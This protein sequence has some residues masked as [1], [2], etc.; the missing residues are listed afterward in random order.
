MALRD[1]RSL[2]PLVTRVVP[3][4]GRMAP[5]IWRFE[6]VQRQRFKTTSRI[7]LAATR[8]R[9]ASSRYAGG[10]PCDAPPASC[11]DPYSRSRRC[12]IL[13]PIWYPP[14]HLPLRATAHHSQAG[15]E[16]MR[17][18]VDDPLPMTRCS[19]AIASGQQK[20][21]QV[22]GWLVWPTGWPRRQEIF[23]WTR[24]LNGGTEAYDGR[25]ACSSLLAAHVR[26]W[27]CLPSS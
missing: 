6:V 13:A 2:I 21:L 27:R 22:T 11:E 7:R 5:D 25:V 10:A 1:L 8:L 26:R 12:T 4:L 3:S 17:K 15:A 19:R 23:L 9:L 20:S 16:S 24:A 18:L 14:Y